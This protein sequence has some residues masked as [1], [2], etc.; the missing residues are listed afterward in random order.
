MFHLVIGK[1]VYRR[2]FEFNSRRLTTRLR[3]SDP[4]NLGF[5]VVPSWLRQWICHS[6]SAL[7]WDSTFNP[8]RTSVISPVAARHGVEREIADVDPRTGAHHRR[9]SRG[10]PLRDAKNRVFPF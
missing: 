4:L 6:G 9:R 2:V 3:A 8:V 1:P 10:L 7:M 5:R